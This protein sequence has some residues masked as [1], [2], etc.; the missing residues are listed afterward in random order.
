ME[1]KEIKEKLERLEWLEIREDL[2]RHETKKRLER[3]IGIYGSLISIRK[4]LKNIKEDIF[5]KVEHLDN[6]SFDISN[7]EI[8]VEN[9]IDEGFNELED[10]IEK[11]QDEKI[12]K[13]EIKSAN[14]LKEKL[15]KILGG[16]I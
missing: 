2:R 9:M 15:K 6:L 3:L 13:E 14:I 8:T 1:K 16:I 5:K 7:T 4:D 12:K 10:S 11:I